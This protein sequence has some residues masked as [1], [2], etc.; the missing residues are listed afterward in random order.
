MPSPISHLLSPAEALRGLR[1]CFL[2]G[3]LGQGGA[4]RQLYYILNCLKHCGADVS[5]LSLTRGEFWEQPI[6]ELGV[7][8][9]HVGDKKSRLIRLARIVG[10]LR[11]LRPVVLQSQHFFTNIYTALAGRLLAVPAIAGVRNDG[12]S[13]IN[14]KHGAF[15]RLALRLSPRWA[16]NSRHAIETLAAL[17]FDR[18]RFDFLPNVVDTKH[19]AP[20]ERRSEIGHP[21]TMLG[22]GSLVVAKRFDLFLDV[23]SRVAAD[24]QTAVRAR[25][26]G[27]GP[28]WNC[29]ESQVVSLRSKGIDAQLVGRVSDPVSLYHAA[30]CLLLTSDHEGTPNVVMEAMA[31]GLPVVA[32]NVGGVADLVKDGE[33]GFLFEP[34]DA[35]GAVSSIAR[36]A[37]EPDLA[38]QIGSRARAFIEKHHSISLLPEILSQLYAKILTAR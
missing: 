20:P 27:D 22:V 16:A 7:P 30:D 14:R 29:L 21:F 36:L 15:R 31:C 28:L 6:R 1:V 12:L 11:R 10:T 38:Q 23:V 18:R 32:T 9:F 8:I 26:A 25:I 37:R 17:G 5:L 2:A 3:T 24:S 33:T 35:A 13:E 19:F 34:G 4:E